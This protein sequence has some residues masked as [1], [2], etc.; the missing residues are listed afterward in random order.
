VYLLRQSPSATPDKE[1]IEAF[2]QAIF[3]DLNMPKALAVLFDVLGKEP[4]G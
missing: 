3:D 1:A 2:E 4:K